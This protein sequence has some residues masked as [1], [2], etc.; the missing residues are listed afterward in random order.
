MRC[1]IMCRRNTASRAFTLIELLVVVLIIGILAAVALPQYTAAVEKSKVSEMMIMVSTIR[2][3][4]KRY[5]LQH[6]AYA[7]TFEELDIEIPGTAVVDGTADIRRTKDF[8]YSIISTYVPNIYTARKTGSGPYAF[9][10]AL[11]PTG[12]SYCCWR[13]E[14]HQKLCTLLGFTVP[15]N[16]NAVGISLGCQADK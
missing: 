3:A 10:F 7:T 8:Q 12:K 13:E 16:N 2:E 15:A 1:S 14:K 11:L 5:F 9:N 6:D 4:Q